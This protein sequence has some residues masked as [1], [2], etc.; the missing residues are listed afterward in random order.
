MPNEEKKVTISKQDY[1]SLMQRL[2]EVEGGEKRTVL[3][4]P[5]FRTA[6]IRLYNEV[7]VIAYGKL[8]EKKIDDGQG[9]WDVLLML[10]FTLV[11]GTEKEEQY[12]KFLRETSYVDCKIVKMELV[13]E[14]EKELGMVKLVEYGEWNAKD[15]GVMVPN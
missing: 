4:R 11:D 12:I 8:K 3:S 15:T 9:G 14:G 2:K 10:P 1:D 13:D 6:R 5:K 7:P